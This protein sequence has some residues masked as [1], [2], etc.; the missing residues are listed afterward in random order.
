MVNYQTY[1]NISMYDSLAMYV[2]KNIDQLSTEELNI[3]IFQGHYELSPIPTVMFHKFKKITV[4]HILQDYEYLIRF[5]KNTFLFYNTAMIQFL[6][7]MIF[8]IDLI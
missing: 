4:L 5:F 7:Y 2:F 3:F 8:H 6:Q 1:L